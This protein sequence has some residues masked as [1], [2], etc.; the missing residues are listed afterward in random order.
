MIK[1]RRVTTLMPQYKTVV[2]M[3][4]EA[5]PD[6]ER[7]PLLYL[8]FLSWRKGV[9]FTAYYDGSDIIGMTYTVET[10][11]MIFVLYL[12]TNVAVRSNG[13]GT[14]ILQ[15]L[16]R[17]N[18]NREVVLNIEPLDEFAENAEQR[19]RRWRFYQKNGFLMTGYLLEEDG[20]YFEILSTSTS[21]SVADYIKNVG[22]LSFGLQKVT[23]VEKQYFRVVIL[24]KMPENVRFW[25]KCVVQNGVTTNHLVYW[26]K[27]T[28]GGNVNYGI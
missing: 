10:D 28:S 20:Q 19:E 21:F 14:K 26:Q 4:N 6:S 8:K 23:V 22:R 9:S 7:L 11:Q 16:I 12:T 2:D 24:D 13:Y 1:T 3:Y 18:A 25:M 27:N 15:E 17:R 5:F